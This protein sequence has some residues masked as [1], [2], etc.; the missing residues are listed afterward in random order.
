MP[1]SR[2]SNSLSCHSQF[3]SLRSV[4]ITRVSFFGG[5]SSLL[6]SLLPHRANC[7]K[8]IENELLVGT[9]PFRVRFEI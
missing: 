4:A 7:N 9:A 6:Q 2:S 3:L 1:R 5:Q 8:V